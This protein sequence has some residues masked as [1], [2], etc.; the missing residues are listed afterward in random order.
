MSYTFELGFG[1]SIQNTIC[2]ADQF[3]EQLASCVAL[4][5]EK[6]IQHHIL[7]SYD[8][9]P[10]PLSEYFSQLLLAQFNTPRPSLPAIS[11]RHNTPQKALLTLQSLA[12]TEDIL[13]TFN[14]TS[15][16]DTSILIQYAQEQSMPLIEIGGN[17]VAHYEQHIV[18][19]IN[20]K[21]EHQ[22]ESYL[23]VIHQLCHAIESQLFGIQS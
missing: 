19:P 2:C 4:I 13:L 5:S 10:L 12:Q 17:Q 20:T 22:L 1:E 21:T 3:S 14:S 9:T 11:L 18:L 23:I 6:L 16:T 8:N 7:W 15:E